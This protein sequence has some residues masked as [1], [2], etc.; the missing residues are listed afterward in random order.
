[1]NK[2]LL[3]SLLLVFNFIISSGQNPQPSWV[4][5][6]PETGNKTYIAREHVTLKPGFSYT[7]SNNNSFIAKIDECLLFPPTDATYGNPSGAAGPT[8]SA[9]GVVGS[10]PGQF[11]VSPS[12]AATYSIP[13]EVPA[14]I[15]GMQP[16]LSIFF[17]SQAGVGYGGLNFDLSGISSITRVP[18]N[19][20]FDNGLHPISFDGNDRFVMDGQ[21]L[22]ALTG[23]YG[24]N[25]TTYGFASEDFTRIT[26]KETLGD[27]PK[28][29]EVKLKS[30]LTLEFG[31]SQ[32]ARMVLS[33]QKGVYTWFV[34]KVKDNF[35]NYIK[36][37]YASKEDGETW[38]SSIEYNGN[39]NTSIEPTCKIEF[40]YYTLQELNVNTSLTPVFIGGN[41]ITFGKILKNIKVFSN[42]NLIK[43]YT[44]KFN[45]PSSSDVHLIGRPLLS[46]VEVINQQGEK[47]IPIAFMRGDLAPATPAL[48]VIEG[49]ILV[50]G[51]FTGDGIQ[52]VATISNDMIIKIHKLVNN[53]WTIIKSSNLNEESYAVGPRSLKNIGDINND[54]IDDLIFSYVAVNM[55]HGI[56]IHL[57]GVL[58]GA[59]LKMRNDN[60]KQWVHDPIVGKF[61]NDGSNSIILI[62]TIN[63]NYSL[64]LKNGTYENLTFAD[65]FSY[66]N[67]K[68]VF[69]GDF[70]G[71]GKSDI[72]IHTNDALRFYTIEGSQFILKNVVNKTVETCFVG[73]L[74]GDGISDVFEEKPARKIHYVSN[75]NIIEEKNA[76]SFY[77]PYLSDKNHWDHR[78]IGSPYMNSDRLLLQ[79]ERKIEE[80]L[81]GIG[82]LGKN[83]CSG[84]FLV[85]S[86]YEEYDSYCIF[87]DPG[88][89]SLGGVSWRDS[90][91]AEWEMKIRMLDFSGSNYGIEKIPGHNKWP[92]FYYKIRI[93][94]FGFNYLQR[95]TFGGGWRWQERIDNNIVPSDISDF[96][97]ADFA[98]S[99]RNYLTLIM[100]SSGRKSFRRIG[101]F[102]DYLET[103]AVKSIKES[104]GG[105][106]KIEDK[107][108]IHNNGC[109]TKGSG[110]LYPLKDEKGVQRVVSKVVTPNGH[111]ISYLYSGGITHQSGKGFLGFK[112]I[113]QT[114]NQTGFEIEDIK[115]LNTTYYELIPDFTETRVAGSSVN[116]VQLGLSMI[117][118]GGKRYLS[119]LNSSTS[120]DYLTNTSVIKSFSNYDSHG[121]AKTIIN[122]FGG[123]ISQNKAL[124]YETKGSWCP[125][126]VT[127]II[128]TLTNNTGSATFEKSFDYNSNGSLQK[129]TINP[130]ND[131]SFK[132]VKEYLY[133]GFGNVTMESVTN[134]NVTKSKNMV[135]SPSG[136]FLISE[137]NNQLDETVTFQ[138]DEGR[139]V[140]KNA[141]TSIGATSIGTTTYEYDGF[142]RLIKTKQPTNIETIN[143][144]QWA[145]GAG[146]VGAKYYTY[147]ETTGQ[148]SVKIWY[149]GLSRELRRDFYGLGEKLTSIATEYDGSTGR[150]FRV[151]EPFYTS[152]GPSTW[153]TVY[154]FYTNGRVEEVTD[155]TGITSYVYNGLKTTITS[156]SGISE[157]TTNS[158]GQVITSKVNGK[159]VTFSYFP[160]GLPRSSTPEGGPA[161]IM[162]YDLLGNQ[163]KIIDPDAGT[164]ETKYNGFGEL[165]ERKQKIHSDALVVTSYNYLPSGLVNEMNLNGE[166]TKHEYDSKK[167]LKKVS[168]GSNKTHVKEYKYDDFNRPISVTETIENNKVFTSSSEYDSFGRIKKETYPT[169][170]YTTNQ[171]DKFGYLKS[172]TSSNGSIVFEANEAN[173]KG[174]LTKYT[175][176][177][178]EVTIAYDNK[179]NMPTSI[180]ANGIINLSFG[181]NA[182]GNL[183]WR[184]DA[185]HTENFRYDI[186]NR[187]EYYEVL[188]NGV[189]AQTYNMAYNTATGEITNKPFVGYEM[190]YK[191]EGKPVHALSKV[192]GLPTGMSGTVGTVLQAIDYTDF[193]KIKLITQGNKTHQLTY[194]VNQQRIKGVFATSGNTT[195]TRYY[196]GN[197]EEEHTPDGTPDGKVRKLHY[198]SGGNGLAA[199]M[200][201]NGGV[202]S[203]YYTYSDY[204]GNLLAVTDAAGSVKQRYAYDPWG[205]RRNPT[206]WTQLDTRPKLLFARGYTM[207][208]HLDDFR[209]INM[210]GRAYDPVMAQF[211]SPDPFIQAPGNWY[212]YNRYGYCLNNPLIYNDP[213]GYKWNWNWL[214]PVH[215]MSKGMQ[216]INDNTTGLRQT[217][218]DIGVPDFNAGY[219][220]AQGSFHSFG[221]SGNIYHNQ[222]DPAASVE[223]GLNQMRFTEAVRSG[224]M[225][226]W[227]GKVYESISN[228]SLGVAAN[229]LSSSV[230]GQISFGTSVG[231]GKGA[232]SLIEKEHIRQAVFNESIA[233]PNF[234][235]TEAPYVSLN[236]PKWLKFVGKYGGFGFSAWGAFDIYNQYET[237]QIAA[238]EMWREQG[239]N[240][241]GALPLVGTGWTIGWEAGRAIC[242][243]SGYQQFKYNFWKNYY[244]WRMGGSID[245]NSVLWNHFHR[246]YKQ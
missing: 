27:G 224:N 28:W 152:S 169:G 226:A 214:N 77:I 58:D 20:H 145:G 114:N 1:M 195:L 120:F 49:P 182:K 239:A 43:T 200:V 123:G 217:M 193:N 103:S 95:N 48:P 202:D 83:D 238:S 242:S 186:A 41:R 168:I 3:L 53:V 68:K 93:S 147:S 137:K 153:A 227:D 90:R 178:R 45:I 52:E 176:G 245:S 232:M 215:W 56:D 122:N 59:T 244:E 10:I 162:E 118:L 31:N 63:R 149:D 111:E 116:K 196:L 101:S 110:S 46:S 233:H 54:G 174:Q 175:Q 129:M 29:F 72:L 225:A 21:R 183:D 50:E 124:L 109:Y 158:A 191:G 82:D 94:Q 75:F 112:S 216:W 89:G 190:T 38:I 157:T 188:K 212:N 40:N 47:L 42:N 163:T 104:L 154:K 119:R 64:I 160:N 24:S 91:I 9:G 7:A 235:S 201:N 220:T 189:L 185:S 107:P 138:Y 125:N 86:T 130:N 108:L 62:S 36:Y 73:D 213:T 139:G 197:Y 184:K 85:G 100:G 35:G 23:N 11:N 173:A 22:I 155:P 221:N 51:D 180:V 37:N 203:L 34:N 167:R 60:I 164:I 208:E 199:I 97:I 240:A 115:T 219:N 26:S 30:G 57:Y 210:N 223:N 79:I 39:Q 5:T 207:H 12:G 32:D 105:E 136:R 205:L 102:F 6:A 144:Y 55:M 229:G 135:Y 16:D 92:Y 166:I 87:E 131:V 78:L 106:I 172:V 17:N 44:L 243:T 148:S 156:P 179:W 84:M 8:P 236:A 133:D 15:N 140:L 194:G 134:N 161:V 211:L 14:G 187:L 143:A 159:I 4:L 113:K 18:H 222:F 141:T 150:V 230:I 171:F 117:N 126:V 25:G 88:P 241:V 206:N 65:G 19:L 99:G 98:G 70:N 128:T 96:C 209:L 67:I 13:I 177:G 204:Q 66:Q 198:I 246:H 228:V 132:I 142:S 151:S 146:P 80:K 218:T 192:A 127:S 74:N 33:D 81:L 69:S 71:D 170:F 121:N 181:Y 234:R 61:T 76:P 231:L 2:F 165:L 237:K